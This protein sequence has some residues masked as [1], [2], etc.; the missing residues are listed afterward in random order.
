[1]IKKLHSY[2]N[3]KL[4]TV[5]LLDPHNMNAGATVETYL[6]RDSTGRRFTCAKGMYKKTEEEAV[7]EYLK[8]LGE[9]LTQKEW[10]INDLLKEKK[11]IE[12]EIA[13]LKEIQN[14]ISQS[15][16]AARD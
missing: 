10:D 2:W 1:M 12:K 11:E 13:K 7:A 15:K 8:D 4:K 14:R 5:T 9:A 6:C 16:I 3:G